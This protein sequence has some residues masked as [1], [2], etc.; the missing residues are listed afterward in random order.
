M[1]VVIY[2]FG[3]KATPACLKIN[4]LVEV[5]QTEEI[6]VHVGI[7]LHSSSGRETLMWSRA[8]L[9]SVCDRGD[10]YPALSFMACANLV[11]H[12]KDV[13]AQ[14]HHRLASCFQ[15]DIVTGTKILCLQLY[16]SSPSYFPKEFHAISGLLVAAKCFHQQVGKNLTCCH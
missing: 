5:I 15:T 8:G 10:L 14:V 12:S 2:A 16:N 4:E 7:D 11:V 1:K 13:M 6:Y 3:Q 9:E